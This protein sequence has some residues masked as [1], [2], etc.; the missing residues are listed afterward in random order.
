MSGPIKRA[1]NQPSDDL[2]KE[3]ERSYDPDL[4]L[5]SDD[6]L[7][8]P[9]AKKTKKVAMG[10][11]ENWQETT[12]KPK[13]PLGRGSANNFCFEVDLSKVKVIDFRD[14]MTF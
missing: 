2:I 10:E 8:F 11:N 1:N 12:E 9:P 13:I 7:N 14:L 3:E 5:G 6:S 4:G